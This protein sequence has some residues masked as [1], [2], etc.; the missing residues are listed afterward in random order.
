M[1]A[2]SREGRSGD[3]SRVWEWIGSV[4]G[5]IEDAMPEWPSS[6]A[7]IERR[8]SGRKRLSWGGGGLSQSSPLAGVTV[9]KG[10]EMQERYGKGTTEHLSVVDKRRWDEGR[11]IY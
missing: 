4:S 11:P 9:G 3:V 6:S 8:R 5:L 2:M 1:R 10:E 7:G